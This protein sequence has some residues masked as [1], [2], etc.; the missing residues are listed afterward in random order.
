MH[1]DGV[2]DFGGDVKLAHFIEK[3]SALRAGLIEADHI[4]SGA[5]QATVDYLVSD[6]SH[7]SP[8]A[9]T[10]KPFPIA[11]NGA[12]P[13]GIINFFVQCIDEI[14]RLKIRPNR[15]TE[16]LLASIKKLV[17]GA[18]GTYE[19]AWLKT[20]EGRSAALDR[21]TSTAIDALLVNL[22]RKSLGSIKGV[23]KKYFGVGERPYFKIFPAIGNVEIKCLFPPN[24]IDKASSAVEHTATV[25]GELHYTEGEF[26][27]FE[28]KVRDIRVHKKD[29]ELPTLMSLFGAVPN[30][31]GEMSAVEF[32]RFN[33]NG[34]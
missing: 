15:V 4:I 32:I 34:W 31:T 2:T 23:V 8:A 7:S 10:L 13:V 1:I 30:A 19:R 6:L 12:D 9:V 17:S 24:L 5:S 26:W 18:E 21:E 22:T 28:V 3:L 11:D 20:S 14:R 27:P 29:S 33:R 16:N 25:E